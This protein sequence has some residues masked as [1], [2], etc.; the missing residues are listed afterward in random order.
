M[1]LEGLDLLIAIIGVAVTLLIGILSLMYNFANREEER[2]KAEQARLRREIINEVKAEVYRD[3]A[4]W[5]AT[6]L[7]R[8]R[9]IDR[10]VVKD[11]ES[12]GAERD[13]DESDSKQSGNYS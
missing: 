9:S 5:G 7:A 12:S 6:G 10:L 1:T 4:N 8:E 11:T 2:S 13:D 3:L